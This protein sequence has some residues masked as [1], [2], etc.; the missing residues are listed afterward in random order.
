VPP[1]TFKQ[2]DVAAAI[3]AA[4]QAGQQVDRVEIRR[5]GNI[6][7]ILTNGKEQH[8]N[9]KLATSDEWADLA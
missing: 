1:T 6:V 8:V 7:V 9:D 3:K 4:V 2:R 5:D